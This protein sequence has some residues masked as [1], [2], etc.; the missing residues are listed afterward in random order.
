MYFIM[1]TINITLSFVVHYLL[2]KL[3]RE[4]ASFL[5]FIFML[6]DTYIFLDTRYNTTNENAVVLIFI[7]IIL[8]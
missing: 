8:S 2:V 3:Y 6:L 5:F 4:T 1:Y 7:I